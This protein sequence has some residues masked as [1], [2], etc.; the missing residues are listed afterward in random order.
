MTEPYA[1]PE[2][3]VWT[4]L[5]ETADV[6][7]EQ[8]L[9]SR[10]P[11]QSFNYLAL[12]NIEHGTGRIAGFSPAK[13]AEIKSNKFR[14]TREHVLY[15]K[16]RP[17]L[18][19]AVAP[20]FEGIA[21]TDLLPLK[22]RSGVLDRH[23]LMW[24]LLSPE[25]LEYVTLKQTGVKMP[26][27]RTG[28]LKGMPLPLPPHAEQLCIVAKLEALLHE[29]R[30]TREALQRIPSLVK[31][32]RQSVLAAAFRGQLVAQDPRD[33]P[34]AALLE[35]IRAERRQ[36]WAA[37]GKDP[38]RYMEPAALD[39]VGLG[40]L[41]AGWVWTSLD[42]CT[43]LITKGESPRWQGHEYVASGVPFVRSE[44][45]LWGTLDVSSPVHI[46][47]EF[48]RK[49]AR[50]Q[51]RPQDVLINLVGASIGRSAVVP[52][53]LERGNV[54][55]AVAVIR[56]NAALLPEYLMYLLISPSVQATLQGEKVDVARANISLTNLR[57]LSICLPP[58][59]EQRRIVARIEALF[60]QADAVEAA[61]ARGLR[62]VEQF[63]QSALA[64]AFR[65]ELV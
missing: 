50:S 56:V 24:W 62:R 45:V 21:A 48:H 16:L 64:R 59:A 28:D 5:G 29:A 1:L 60:A 18:R 58:L 12:E 57:E 19:K 38:A 9:P 51:L 37:Q 36:R 32:F 26:R 25:V 49:L 54:N 61:V 30:R 3:W 39:A 7:S 55:Q 52:D 13:G 15:G 42:A 27:L 46:P 22:P 17:Y 63:E 43:D 35:R 20:E 40:E 14:F 41:P 11:Q 33:E 6:G 65:G 47:E 10:F 2:G 53:S 4:T 31:R 44:N 8:I 23:F 34:A